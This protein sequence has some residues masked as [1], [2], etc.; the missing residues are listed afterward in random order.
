MLIEVKPGGVLIS[1][2]INLSV[3]RSKK[4]SL[5]SQELEANYNPE[6]NGERPNRHSA[7]KYL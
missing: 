6:S 2:T 1:L 4:K 3:L 7:K 5:H